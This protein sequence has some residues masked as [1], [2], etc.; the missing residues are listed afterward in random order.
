MSLTL[1]LNGKKTTLDCSPTDRLLDALRISG[2]MS[3][4][5]EGCGEGECGACTVRVNGTAVLSCLT[6]AGQVEGLKVDTVASVR[7]TNHPIIEEMGKATGS[8]Q[9][10][11]CTPGFVMSATALLDDNPSPSRDEIQVA[12]SGNLCRCTGYH[13]IFDAVENAAAAV[14]KEAGKKPVKKTNKKTAKRAR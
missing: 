11:F 13:K 12:L 3:E 9:C 14:Q 10:G 7:A 6:L 4:V 1:I 8:V 5:K 2:H